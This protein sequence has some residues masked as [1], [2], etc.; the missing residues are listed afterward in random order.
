[1]ALPENQM[2]RVLAGTMRH[3]NAKACFPLRC[4]R[5]RV[6]VRA[7]VRELVCIWHAPGSP[8][9]HFSRLECA[10][11]V[12]TLP[13]IRL[14]RNSLRFAHVGSIGEPRVASVWAHEENVGM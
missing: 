3:W 11:C 7:H 10:L 9:A 14:M 6:R 2:P 1:M 8:C 12:C 5:V 4:A 13:G